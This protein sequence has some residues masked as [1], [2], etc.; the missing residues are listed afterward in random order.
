MLLNPLLAGICFFLVPD[1]TAENIMLSKPSKLSDGSGLTVYVNDGH[2][3]NQDAY[4]GLMPFPFW[5]GDLL[6][7][8]TVHN[9]SVT[10]DVVY[11]TGY[12]LRGAF[13]GVSID[14]NSQCPDAEIFVCG[15]CPKDIGAGETVT[16]NC[17][18]QL[19]V[20]F[21]KVWRN[22]TGY[23]ALNEVAVEGTPQHRSGAKYRKLHNYQA[24]SS[25]TSLT[26]AS[27]NDCGLRCHLSQPCLSFSYHPTAA[28]N[29]FLTANP[30][31]GV[32]AVGWTKY[33]IETC[34]SNITCDLTHHFN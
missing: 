4:T 26:T 7:F 21:V 3:A 17:S 5:Q 22:I 31:G 8:Y 16:F 19:P 27:A 6:G 33:T 15:Q 18:H 23:L 28:P 24:A 30:T 29:C 10:S 32:S 2:T 25:M 12:Y 14:D 34:S 20:R 9:I 13:V 11:S 1:I